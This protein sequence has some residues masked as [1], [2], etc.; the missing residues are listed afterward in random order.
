MTFLLIIFGVVS[1]TLLSVFIGLLGAD[2][3]IGFTWA[4]L[5]S[6]IFTPIIGIIAVILSERLPADQK[7]W[8]CIVPLI[9]IVTVVMIICFMIGLFSLVLSN[10]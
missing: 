5:L 3:R 2:R 10:I 7:R 1:G 4:F 9:T 6:L 8:G